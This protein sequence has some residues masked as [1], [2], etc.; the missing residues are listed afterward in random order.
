MNV[1]GSESTESR[2]A[3]TGLASMSI[4]TWA[5]S[6]RSPH[7]WLTTRRTPAHVAHHPGATVEHRAHHGG[8]YQRSGERGDG[9][10]HRSGHDCLNPSRAMVTPRVMPSIMTSE[11]RAPSLVGATPNGSF[12]PGR[13]VLNAPSTAAFLSSGTRWSA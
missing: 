11:P 6:G 13:L 1:V 3:A 8:Q 5:T 9:G 12:W 2:R 7:T 4:S 10:D